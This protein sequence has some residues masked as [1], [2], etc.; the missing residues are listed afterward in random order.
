M[1]DVHDSATRSYNMSRI[2]SKNTTP[3]LKVRRFLFKEGFRYRI[4][5]SNLPGKPDIVLKK[6]NTVIFINGC[7]W[8]GHKNCKY[9]VIPRTRKDWWIR[10]INKNKQNDS[11]KMRILRKLG[12]KVIIIYECKLKNDKLNK[13][14]TKLKKQI[15][16]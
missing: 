4:H 7:F 10:K 6:Y 16:K 11:S 15:L 13:T 9:F 3:E 2:K 8:H 5:C 12:W 14:M 1:S